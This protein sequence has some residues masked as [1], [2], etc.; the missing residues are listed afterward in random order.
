MA[1]YMLEFKRNYSPTM[2]QERHEM[3]PIGEVFAANIIESTSNDRS[4]DNKPRDKLEREAAQVAPPRIS[5]NFRAPVND[6]TNRRCQEWTTD[7]VRRLVDNGVIAQ[8]AF[9]IVQ[10]K[11]DPP[12]HGIV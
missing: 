12:G 1:G 3:Y 10:D 5:E 9:D 2:T 6:T 11:R 8:T 7:F 4:R